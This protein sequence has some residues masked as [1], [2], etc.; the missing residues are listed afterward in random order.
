MLNVIHVPDKHSEI[1]KDHSLNAI[2]TL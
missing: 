2:P 1:N